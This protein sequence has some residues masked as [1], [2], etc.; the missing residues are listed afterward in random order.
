M[1][2]ARAGPT[3][4]IAR[5]TWLNFAASR[6]L[7]AIGQS[8]GQLRDADIGSRVFP[9]PGSCWSV[10]LAGMLLAWTALL[11]GTDPGASGNPD[12]VEPARHGSW[13]ATG[14]HEKTGRQPKP[15]ARSPMVRASGRHL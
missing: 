2:A 5:S 9:A 14:Y 13:T 7:L 11:K 10:S 8:Q 3:P 15:L 12:G 1:A 6:A 4:G